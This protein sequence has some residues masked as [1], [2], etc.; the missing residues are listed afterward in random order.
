MGIS[1]SNYSDATYPI[2]TAGSGYVYNNGGEM[3]IGSQTDDLILFAGGVATTNWA[4]RA[5]KTTQALT[6]KA[7]LTLGGI[8]SVN[9]ATIAKGEVIESV[10]AANEQV[11]EGSAVKL[12]VSDGQVLVPSVVGMGATDA[13]RAMEGTDVG[14]TAIVQ[15]LA[16]CTS[17]GGTAGTVI[18]WTQAMTLTSGGNLILTTGT[19]SDNGAR[20]HVSGRAYIN[21]V[22]GSVAG[23]TIYGHD[24]ANVR[25]R[26]ENV[27]GR[28]WELTGGLTGANNSDFTIYDV[29]AAATR[30]AINSSGNVLIGTTTDNGYRLRVNGTGWFD[31]NVIIVPQSA[32][33]AEGLSFTMPTVS[34]W[35]GLRWRRE[36]GDNDGNWYV[37]FTALDA[38]DD[39]VFGA[40]NGGAQVD[41]I[42]RLVKNGNVL[43]G[44]AT[45][46]GY[47]LNIA[48]NA[49]IVRTGTSTALVVGLSGVTGS[50]IRFSYNG[51]FVGS[52]STDGS[53]TAYNTS[54]DYRLKQDIKDFNGLDLLSRIKTYDFE[55]KS[56]KT[57]S[58]G[59]LAHELQEVINYAVTGSKDAEEM[60]GVDY[61]KIVPILIKAIQELN[62]KIK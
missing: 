19:V 13:R 38:T 44:T 35:G 51:G 4:L 12:L 7:G 43:M 8:T 46:A 31:N 32:S 55:W 21:N 61:S 9:S 41:N 62:E 42:I 2:F 48:G 28:T 22:G 59:V 56:D 54:S 29:T 23:T 47:R 6:T 33:W 39:L 20:L 50:I 3:I 1:S 24:Q 36:R 26:L 17:G 37:G 27:S 53:N 34:R 30:L 10:P 45:D 11:T 5:N 18:S 60:Q 52:I 16:T 25:L 57:R 40:N 49:Q 58:Y 14:F 15:P